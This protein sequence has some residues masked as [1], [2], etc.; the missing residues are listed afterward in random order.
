MSS[1]RVPRSPSVP[2]SLLSPGQE[3][4][5]GHHNITQIPAAQR[6]NSGRGQHSGKHPIPLS[7]FT[8]QHRTDS[9]MYVSAHSPS[10]GEFHTERNVSCNRGPVS[11]QG[12]ALALEDDLV[13]PDSSRPASAYNSTTSLQSFASSSSTT[14]SESSTTSTS[15]SNGPLGHFET[16][17]PPGGRKTSFR[18]SSYTRPAESLDNLDTPPASEP[19]KALSDYNAQSSALDIHN[20]YPSLV[21]SPERQERAANRRPFRVPV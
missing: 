16:R 12:L 7:M 18:Q 9:P 8:S 14:V 2:T 6:R 4:R 20:S 10:H 15:S 3:D 17:F 5:P 11:A 13:T 1:L 19:A 21:P